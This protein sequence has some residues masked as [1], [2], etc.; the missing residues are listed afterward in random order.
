MTFS[1]SAS[2]FCSG[3]NQ[4][5][6][7]WIASPQFSPSSPPSS[8]P[9]NHYHRSCTHR[10]QCGHNMFQNTDFRDTSDQNGEK[11]NAHKQTRPPQHVPFKQPDRDSVKLRPSGEAATTGCLTTGRSS[12]REN[13]TAGFSGD[14]RQLKQPYGFR[15]RISLQHILHRQALRCGIHQ[16]SL[17]GP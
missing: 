10:T 4:T 2:W 3:L 14:Q 9:H 15:T 8:P 5:L 1:G 7:I 17:L 16:G 11:A 6:S 13:P 12:R